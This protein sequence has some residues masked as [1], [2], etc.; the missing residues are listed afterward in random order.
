MGG[1]VLRPQGSIPSAEGEIGG[2]AGKV[3]VRDRYSEA[4]GEVLSTLCLG[5]SRSQLE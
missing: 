5:T 2:E 3:R 4:V 1:C